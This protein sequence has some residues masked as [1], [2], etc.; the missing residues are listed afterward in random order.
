MVETY[1][2]GAELR[3]KGTKID[4]WYV[5]LNPKGGHV[6]AWEDRSNYDGF[7]YSSV[8]DDELKNYVPRPIT[9]GDTF[10]REYYHDTYTFVA[11]FEFGDEVYGREYTGDVEEAE[12]S[13]W[14]AESYTRDRLNEDDWTRVT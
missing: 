7:D 8:T 6:V 2:N 3:H 10:T 12:D 1:R 9:P 11:M 13:E 4:Y 5:G 14:Y